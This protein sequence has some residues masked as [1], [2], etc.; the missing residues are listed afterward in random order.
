MKYSDYGTQLESLATLH[1]SVHAF[2]DI[3]A[4]VSSKPDPFL[5]FEMNNWTECKVNANNTAII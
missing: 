2:A 1:Y 5:A 4:I 3:T